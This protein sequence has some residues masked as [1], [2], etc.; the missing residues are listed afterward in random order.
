MNSNTTSPA[1]A[2]QK[3]RHAELNSKEKESLIL[4]AKQDQFLKDWAS[5]SEAKELIKKKFYS[6]ALD[7]L[8]LIPVD[9]AP[10]VEASYLKILCQL[11]S[12]KEV[13]GK[14]VALAKQSIKE[15]SRKDLPVS[16]THLT[17]PTICSV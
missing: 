16:Y 10:G 5:L 9:S 8:K 11:K 12:G 7:I 2:L 3:I 1:Q 13:D 4:I 17:L 15:A 14:E 6:K